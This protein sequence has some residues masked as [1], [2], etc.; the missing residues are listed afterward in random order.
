M[1][2][3]NILLKIDSLHV[4]Y[5]EFEAIRNVSLEVPEGSVVSVIGANGSGKSTVLQTISGLLKPAKGSIVFQG[6]N[7]G[8]WMPHQIVDEGICLVPEG[9][10]VFPGL[11]IFE[12]LIIGAYTPRAR[13][14]R[15][16]N[17]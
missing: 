11:S 16:E 13:K 3:A 15:H 12:N 17:L 9:G 2:S 4:N 10:R 14:N 6:K 7:I 5:G 1:T 8:G